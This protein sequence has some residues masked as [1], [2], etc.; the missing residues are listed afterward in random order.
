M[1][2]SSNKD[3]DMTTAAARTQL[4]IYAAKSWPWL[5]HKGRLRELS[6][7]L[8]TWTSRRLRAV[9]NGEPGVSLRAH[10]QDDINNLTEGAANA[11]R[12][13]QAEYRALETRIAAL[14][15]FFAAGDEEHG[16]PH[17]DALRT[18]ASRQ[19][20]VPETGRR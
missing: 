19:G 16:R 12:A 1:E 5:N 9:Y 15:A 20:R 8:T 6:R 14:E 10:E 2:T 4:R 13:S 11:L 17:V 18:I 7:E 3:R